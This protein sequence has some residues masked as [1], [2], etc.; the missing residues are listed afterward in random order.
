[1]EGKLEDPINSAVDLAA[2]HFGSLKIQTV[3]HV[4]DMDDVERFSRRVNDRQSFATIADQWP[5][6]F[7]RA[8]AENRDLRIIVEAGEV[9]LRFRAITL[10]LVAGR[11]LPRRRQW[12]V[13]KMEV[14]NAL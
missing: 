5:E 2:S 10:I 14:R 7:P 1:M 6:D 3:D 13:V 4:H 8:L 9:S 12:L 11:R